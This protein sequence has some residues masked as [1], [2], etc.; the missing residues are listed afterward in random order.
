MSNESVSKSQAI[1]DKQKWA[2][3]FFDYAEAPI[4]EWIAAY[5]EEDPEGVFSD[6]NKESDIL[7]TEEDK[8]YYYLYLTTVP[9][10]I[11]HSF[12]VDKDYFNQSDKLR[13]ASSIMFDAV[14]TVYPPIVKTMV[15]MDHKMEN[16][17]PE[18]IEDGMFFRFKMINSKMIMRHQAISRIGDIDKQLKKIEKYKKIT[19]ANK[20]EDKTNTV[21]TIKTVENKE[22]ME[23]VKPKT[24]EK[25]KKK[26]SRAEELEIQLLQLKA[27]TIQEYYTVTDE[28]VKE[29]EEEC[30]KINKQFEKG[31]FLYICIDNTIDLT[32]DLVG[33]R[34]PQFGMKYQDPEEDTLVDK[35]INETK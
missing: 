32:D 4:K 3:R 35:F 21:E 29:M 30:V 14:Y 33:C 20:K 19:K 23:A 25:S 7:S 28:E 6:Y 31:P 5:L 17:Y 27:D 11:D 26:R 13:K 9:K 10:D 15:N 16:I 18:F 34:L 24:K 22:A 2:M 12:N 1:E 8:K